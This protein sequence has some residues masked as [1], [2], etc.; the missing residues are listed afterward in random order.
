MVIVIEQLPAAAG[1]GLRQFDPEA[2]PGDV[3]LVYTIVARVAGSVVPEPVPVIVEPVAIEWT[4]GC[5]PEPEVIVDVRGRLAVRHTADG[6]SQL[7]VNRL[8]HSDFAE[9]ARS[10]VLNGIGQRLCAA[11]LGAVLNDSVV[12]AGQTHE[13]TSLGDS[14]AQRLLD[15]HIFARDN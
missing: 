9:F 10:H 11:R 14:V 6:T 3:D 5:R 13:Q 15:I 8:G 1:D 2:P 7:V 4:L 12:F